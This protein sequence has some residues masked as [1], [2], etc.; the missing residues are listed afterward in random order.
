MLH[1]LSMQ[2]VCQMVLRCSV[3]DCLDDCRKCF[4][5]GASCPWHT[6]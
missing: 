2:A 4:F 1:D 5:S 3:T 6:V